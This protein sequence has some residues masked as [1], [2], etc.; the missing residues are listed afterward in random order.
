LHSTTCERASLAPAD[1][2]IKPRPTGARTLAAPRTAAATTRSQSSAGARTRRRIRSMR[3]HRRHR[4]ARSRR[5]RFG[6]AAPPRRG[7]RK[8]APLRSG[9]PFP[10]PSFGSKTRNGVKHRCPRAPARLEGRRL[11]AEASDELVGDLRWRFRTPTP[12][13]L[14]TEI[15][16]YVRLRV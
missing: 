5:R 3:A 4:R 9:L 15:P 7:T 16:H 11:G 1:I 14:Y 6:T 10:R 8:A 13:N 12:R 2:H